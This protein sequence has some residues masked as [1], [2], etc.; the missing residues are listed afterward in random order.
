MPKRKTVSFIPA[1]APAAADPMAVPQRSQGPAS[2]QENEAKFP[3]REHAAEQTPADHRDNPRQHVDPPGPDNVPVNAQP[4]ANVPAAARQP[5]PA[6]ITQPA[7]A[8]AGPV[9]QPTPAAQPAAPPPP[10]VA[11]QNCAGGAAPPVLYKY[12]GPMFVSHIVL[13]YETEEGV[14]KYD[15]PR[16]GTPEGVSKASSTFPTISL[17]M[18]SSFFRRRSCARS[19]ALSSGPSRPDSPVHRRT[20]IAVRF[21]APAVPHA[22]RPPSQLGKAP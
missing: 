17:M 3:K 2:D 16:P 5:A 21:Q 7:S 4:V 12:T 6:S 22:R 14:F 1:T 13:V 10:A 19:T 20:R 18:C 9:G 11:A 8:T 15:V